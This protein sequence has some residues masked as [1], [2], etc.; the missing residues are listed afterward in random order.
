MKHQIQISRRD[1]LKTAAVTTAV[2]MPLLIPRHV[3][4]DAAQPGAND[5]V[6]VALIGLGGRCTGIYPHEIKP[7]AG[8]KVVAVSDLLQPRINSFMK[9]YNG[10][11]KPE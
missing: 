7:V 5:T 8:L 3:L 4:G 11:F 6:K 2:A 9:R 1:F 10:D